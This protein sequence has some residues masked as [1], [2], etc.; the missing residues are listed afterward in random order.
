MKKLLFIILFVVPVVNGYCQKIY[1]SNKL[2]YGKTQ[3]DYEATFAKFVDAYN[4]GDAQQVWSI[5]SGKWGE[6]KAKLWSEENI[7][8]IRIQYGDVVSYKYAGCFGEPM[9]TYGNPM[10]YFK[11]V[12]S[13]PAVSHKSSVNG[14]KNHEA[15]ISL[16]EEGKILGIHFAT[17]SFEVGSV[18]NEF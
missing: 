14:R 11:L 4:H 8:M 17:N 13:K 6:Q 10:A 5:M 12:F 2:A 9:D 1:G 16:D 3:A 18:P 15:E 7:K